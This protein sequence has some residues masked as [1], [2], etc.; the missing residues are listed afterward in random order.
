MARDQLADKRCI[1]FDAETSEVFV[2]RWF[3]HNPPTNQKHAKGAMKV[4][5][6]I[7]SDRIRE[8]VEAEF[9]E[10]D[11]GARAS[12]EGLSPLEPLSTTNERLANTRYM[13]NR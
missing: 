2:D 6:R 9:V 10:T 5:C 3:K 13:N 11:W 1:S 7:T 4:I 12:A 8:K